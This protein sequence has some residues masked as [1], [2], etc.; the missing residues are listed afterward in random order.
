MLRTSRREWLGG[1]AACSALGACQSTSLVAPSTAIPGAALSPAEI[2]L[3]EDYALQALDRYMETWNSRD[4]AR[5]ATSLAYPHVRPGANAF[6][7]FRTEQDYITA[8]AQ[9]F[10][11]LLAQG[12][13]YTRWERRQVLQVGLKKVH[14]A[15]WWRRF[16]ENYQA[17][18]SSQI[19]Y[20]VVPTD[21]RIDG[22]W[23]IQARFATGVVENAT[24]DVVAANT[25]KARTALDAYTEAFGSNDP[26]RLAGAV[27]FPHVRHG[28]GRLEYWLTREDYLKSAEPGRGRTWSSTRLRDIRPV[29]V[30]PNGANFTL[31][32]DRLAADGQ[33]LSS[34]AALYLVTTAEN[35][36]VWRVRAISTFGP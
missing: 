29:A 36:P 13:R 31:T 5:W 15:G 34:Y 17:V 4:P 6:E 27:H 19:C 3:R 11:R 20:L 32:Y 21:G 7:V 24:P 18:Q 28:D 35:D 12:W 8:Q 2:A 14:I 1:V 16:G 33:A 10:D 30:S 26:E 22:P 25:A 23:R 9:A